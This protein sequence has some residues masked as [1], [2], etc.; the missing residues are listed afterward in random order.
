MFISAE[1]KLW[2]KARVLTITWATLYRHRFNEELGYNYAW[3]KEQNSNHTRHVRTKK[4]RWL[5]L[6][7]CAIC[8]GTFLLTQGVLSAAQWADLNCYAPVLNARK[9]KY[10]IEEFDLFTLRGEI[11]NFLQVLVSEWLK[12]RKVQD[13]IRQIGARGNS[14]DSVVNSNFSKSK[15]ICC[16]YTKYQITSIV[17]LIVNIA[18]WRVQ[19]ADNSKTFSKPCNSLLLPGKINYWMI[20]L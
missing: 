9:R 11:I 8:L 15:T 4:H 20:V 7:V 13:I 16:V 17:Q 19:I 14:L 3:T 5:T 18:T 6:G 10:D 12:L 1:S 2:A